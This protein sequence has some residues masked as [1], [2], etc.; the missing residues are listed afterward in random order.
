MKNKIDFQFLKRTLIFLSIA[1]ILSIGLIMLGQQY[2]AE[3]LDEYTRVKSSLGKSH[4]KYQKLVK[5]IDLIHLYTQSYK[6]YKKSGLIGT[7]RRLSW[8]ETL[9]SV[10]DVLK[11]PMLSYALGPQEE[12]KLPKLKIDNKILVA[13]TPMKLKIDLLHEEDLFAVLEGIDGNIDNLFTVDSCKITIIGLRKS[14]GLSTKSANLKSNCLL[15]WITVN[16][17]S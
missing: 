7:E 17:Q 4:R 1:L 12:F 8:I 6:D 16:V 2:E 11:L 13:S 14:K 10:N 3:K 15:R 9:E 5:D